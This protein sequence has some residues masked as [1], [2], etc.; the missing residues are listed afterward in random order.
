[1][2]NSG[3]PV[4]RILKSWMISIQICPVDKN[5]LVIIKLCY[6]FWKR[7]H[8]NIVNRV[9]LP[10]WLGIPGSKIYSS[11]S[12]NNMLDLIPVLASLTVYLQV[13]LILILGSLNSK[14]DI[15]LLLRFS[16]LFQP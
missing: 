7:N 8:I 15:E 1:M 6:S 14:Q 13:Y 3:R 10:H 5:L 9:S 4:Y 16:H 2:S 12:I 11:K